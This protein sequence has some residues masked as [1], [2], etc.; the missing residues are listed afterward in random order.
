MSD[1]HALSLAEVARLIQART[2]SPV[3]VTR[4]LLSRI[5]S[6]DRGVNAFLTVT[7]ELALAD[8]RTAEI[9]IAGGRYLGPLHGVP[10]GIKDIYDTQGIRTTGHSRICMNYV[11]SSDATAVRKLRE[12]G[13]VLMGKLATHEF[14]HGGPSFDLP[15][16]P[17]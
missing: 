1:L 12:S 4:A 13:A 7:P 9:D 3:E 14:A 17:A 15:W 6:L 8:A 2:I 11:P 16:P 10:L 5:E